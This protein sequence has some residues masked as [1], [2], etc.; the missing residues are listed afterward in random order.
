MAF[1]KSTA[2]FPGFSVFNNVPDRK[3]QSEDNWE[4][5][6]DVWPGGETEHAEHQQLNQLKSKNCQDP[7]KLKDKKTWHPVKMCIFLCGTRLM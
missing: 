1:N 7:A 6:L 3:E 4:D 2:V 5:H